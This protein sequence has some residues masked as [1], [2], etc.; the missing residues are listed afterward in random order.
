MMK[1]SNYII[2]GKNL[3]KLIHEKGISINRCA[4]ETGVS[5]YAI[6]CYIKQEYKASIDKIIILAKYFNVDLFYLVDEESL[7]QPIIKQE[8]VKKVNKK[9][10]IYN[11]H[12]SMINRIICNKHTNDIE[13]IIKTILNNPSIKE[14]TAFKNK[15]QITSF[16]NREYKKIDW[17]GNRKIKEAWR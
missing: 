14:Q 4:N 2:N 7:H 17:S 13:M 5:N 15:E 12:L 11:A 6:S 16:I 1:Y 8:S 3:K 10:E 9:E